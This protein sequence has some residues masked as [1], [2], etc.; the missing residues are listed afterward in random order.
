MSQ[1]LGLYVH[2]PFCRRRCDFCSFYLEVHHRAAADRFLAALHTEM[3]LHARQDDVRGRPLSSVYFGGGTPTALETSDLI[4]ILDGIRGHFEWSVD[5]EVTIE[6]HPATV[7][8]KDLSALADAGF[9]RMSFGAES[10]EDSELAGIGRAALAGET[11]AAVRQ[12]R[13]AGFADI[14]LDVMYGL[15]GQS[16]ASWNSTLERCLDLTPAHLSCYALTVEP[17]TALAGDIE[18]RRCL[19]P[20]EALQVAM[21]ETA[22]VMLSAAGYERYEI[23]NYAKPGHM[24]RH[25]L[26]YWTHGDYLGLGPSAQSFLNGARFGKTASLN[27]YQ[28]DLAAQRLPLSDHAVLSDQERL[29]DSVIF[30]LRLSRG[31]PTASLSAHGVNYGHGRTISRLRDGHLIEEVDRYTRLTARGRLYADHVAEQLY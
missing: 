26:L 31:V 6:A 20:D 15:P 29:R 22:H 3:A 30:G 10:M 16:I 18:A 27:A 23:S 17:G 13:K 4:G 14:N 1:P 8:L 24:C 25:N 2:I 12:A 9:T 7:V 11:V 28:A 5:C 19:P 21:D